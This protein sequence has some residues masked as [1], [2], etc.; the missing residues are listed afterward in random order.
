[1]IRREKIMI[2]DT[3]KKVFKSFETRPGVEIHITVDGLD[4]KTGRRVVKILKRDNWGGITPPEIDF[5]GGNIHPK[6]DPS[7]KYVDITMYLP[8]NQRRKGESN[9]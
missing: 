4:L 8:N 9:D 2:S 3:L 5:S 1:M 7:Y 6:D